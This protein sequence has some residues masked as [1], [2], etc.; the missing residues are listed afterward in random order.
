MP[1]CGSLSE[2]GQHRAVDNLLDPRTRDLLVQD[3][4]IYNL[5]L[6]TTEGVKCQGR[7]NVFQMLNFLPPQCNVPSEVQD[8][9][10]STHHDRG[11]DDHEDQANPVPEDLERTHGGRRSSIGCLI[12]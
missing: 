2:G 11:D 8:A 9:D 6:T 10:S 4:P 3:D 12:H 5:D 1:R 7:I